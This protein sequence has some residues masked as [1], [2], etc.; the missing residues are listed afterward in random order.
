MARRK[1]LWQIFTPFLIILLAALLAISWSVSKSLHTS[2]TRQTLVELEVRAE[3]I[4]PELISLLQAGKPARINTLC[5]ELGQRTG[6]RFTVIA[7]DGQVLGDSESDAESM[8]NHAG[9]P[10]MVTALAG[11][12]GTATRYST[13]LQQT[14]LYVALPLT[15]DGQVHGSVRASFSAAAL[16]A[17]ISAA[18]R[19]LLGGGI[20]V[21]LCA[22]LVAWLVS[23]RIS[24]PLGLLQQGAQRFAAGNLTPPLTENGSAEIQDLAAA[25]NGMAAQ[26]DERLRTVLRQR[27]EQ[28]AI[29]ASMVE[30]VIAFDTEEKVLRLN[31]AAALLLEIEFKTAP[32]RALSE[33]TRKTDVQ[34]FVRRALADNESVEA[35]LTLLRQGQEFFLQVHGSP[36]RDAS[37]TV[38]GALIVLHDVTRLRRLETLR[39]DFVANVSHEL[40]TPITAIK[41]AIETLREGA[42]QEPEH[43]GRFFDI[44]VRQADRLN[45]IVEDLLSLSRLERGAEAE[46]IRLERQKL[47]PVLEHAVQDCA[48]TAAGQ[49][50][51][52]NIACSPQLAGRLNSALLEQAISN[53]LDNAIKYSPARSV[54]SIE[55]WQE[56]DQVRIKVQDRGCG[57]PAEHLPRLF[58][59]FYRVDAARSRSLGGTGLGL[60]IVKHIVQAHGGTVNAYSTPGQ[61]SSFII[62]LP[63]I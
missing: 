53:L 2:L 21:A 25:M 41:G 46:E 50:V 42:L 17:T 38:I 61:G 8:D 56:E 28:N 57:I 60:S 3:L 62:N 30:G 36:L 22:G 9:R 16:E 15:A 45:T 34:K 20:A 40:K 1:L 47:L 49:E 54:V 29:F 44:A 6:T 19:P 4:R 10:E 39:R 58:E 43:A 33:V 11:S 7:A 13:T 27:N 32:G 24:Q 12:T 63:A 14:M 37:G 59:R 26:L 55:A 35:E 5:R 31:R 18:N 52:L 51:A 23:R 48:A